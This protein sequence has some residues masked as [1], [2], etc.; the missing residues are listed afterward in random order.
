MPTFGPSSR[1]IRRWLKI[2]GNQDLIWRGLAPAVAAVVGYLPA[3]AL[4]IGADNETRL[5]LSE[6]YP[7]LKAGLWRDPRDGF[8]YSHALSA[9]RL[10]RCW[11]WA[12]KDD[13][14]LGHPEDVRRLAAE[15]PGPVRFTIHGR[16]QGCLQD[17]S[18]IGLL[19]HP[20]AE[21]DHFPQILN[22]INHDDEVVSS[23]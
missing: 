16:E 4:R 8:D 15:L 5:S 6:T 17:Y 18:H 20:D 12:A 1:T 9:L 19:V 21:R 14:V 11:L 10:P 23:P 22:W 3:R 7:W 13:P 2:M